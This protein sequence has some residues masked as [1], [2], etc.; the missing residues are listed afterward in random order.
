MQDTA[1]T[2]HIGD[3]MHYPPPP[4]LSSEYVPF[5]TDA[6]KL[7]ERIKMDETDKSKELAS[8]YI[9][10]N[11]K[12]GYGICKPSTYYIP[13]SALFEYALGHEIGAYKY[14]QFNWLDDPVSISTYIDAAE[15]H[16]E[17][18]KNGELR[19]DD[20]DIHHLAHAMTCFSIIID[21]GTHGTL[22]DDR[23][24]FREPEKHNHSLTDQLKLVMADIGERR[25]NLIA[26]W[27]GY[28]EHMEAGGTQAEWEKEHA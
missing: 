2:E 22:I 10:G 14:G 13:S 17:A 24:K 23:F 7:K 21:A 8:K 26:R 19:A 3:K 15:R 16:I 28:K 20:T 5:T 27:K 4:P 11:P 6:P 18:F 25:R 1:Q 9:D 12:T